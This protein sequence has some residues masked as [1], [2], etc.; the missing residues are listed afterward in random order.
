MFARSLLEANPGF[1]QFK[2]LRI[3]KLEPKVDAFIWIFNFEHSGVHC[4]E[5]YTSPT[6]T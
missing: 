4:T 2:V 6:P 5:E 3:K 1:I